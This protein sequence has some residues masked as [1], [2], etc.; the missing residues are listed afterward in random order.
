MPP[1]PGT[2]STIHSTLTTE[3]DQKKGIKLP[4]LKILAA[5]DNTTNQMFLQALLENNGHTVSFAKN[6][7]EAIN[8]LKA[9]YFDVVLMDL[10]M[11]IMDGDEATRRIRGLP[12]LMSK[13][14]V[15]ALTASTAAAD[16]ERILSSG[17]NGYLTKPVR[18]ETLLAE[19]KRC[20]SL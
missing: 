7:V 2:V 4:P 9:D 6:G 19:I 17:M 8:L 15:I 10:Q 20:L 5:E 14:P 1:V 12:S 18:Q 13:T 3:N 11:P 16:K